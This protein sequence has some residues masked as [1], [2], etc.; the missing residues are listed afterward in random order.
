M[1]SF[2][3]PFIHPLISVIS[4]KVHSDGIPTNLCNQQHLFYLFF[5]APL[6]SQTFS[7]PL[8][9]ILAPYWPS[10]YS[11]LFSSSSSLPTLPTPPLSLSLSHSGKSCDFSEAEPYKPAVLGGLSVFIALWLAAAASVLGDPPHPT[12]TRFLSGTPWIEAERKGVR[13]FVCVQVLHMQGREYLNEWWLVSCVLFSWGETTCKHVHTQSEMHRLFMLCCG[14]SIAEWTRS[15]HRDSFNPIGSLLRRNRA[16]CQLLC[17]KV[18]LFN[19]PVSRS[20]PS[21]RF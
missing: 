18:P 14:R 6:I 15:Q 7:S 1:H 16:V 10:L 13:M 17:R 5:F 4:H 9:A 12:P 21:V 20:E 19:Y 3:P 11:S 2:I 8:T